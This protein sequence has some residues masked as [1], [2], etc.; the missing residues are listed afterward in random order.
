[1]P[2]CDN[3]LAVDDD[4]DD[5]NNN[6]NCYKTLKFGWRMFKIKVLTVFETVREKETKGAEDSWWEVSMIVH[7][8][9]K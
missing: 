9:Y 5:N 4:D 3:P 2:P 6:N 7:A 8:E 1:M